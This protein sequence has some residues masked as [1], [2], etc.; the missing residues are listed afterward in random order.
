MKRERGRLTIKVNLKR[1]ELIGLGG[2]MHNDKE[3]ICPKDSPSSNTHASNN[4]ASKYKK[5][6]SEN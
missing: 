6:L 4:S 5:K 3:S 1:R 2:A